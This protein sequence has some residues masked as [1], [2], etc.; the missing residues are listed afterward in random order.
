MLKKLAADEAGRVR[1]EAVRAAS[2][3]S[4]P[5]AIE[6]AFITADQPTDPYL[7]F[8]RRNDEATRSNLQGGVAKG[9]DVKFTTDSGARYFLRNVTLEKLIKMARPRGG[10][11]TDLPARRPR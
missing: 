1:L 8:T 6:V 3:Y 7:D 4:A 11:G 2:F 9:Q 5:E 10:S